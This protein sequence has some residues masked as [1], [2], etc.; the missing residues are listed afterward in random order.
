MEICDDGDHI[1]WEITVCD[2]NDGSKIH[3]RYLI[4]EHDCLTISG[5]DK[6]DTDDIRH[7][8]GFLAKA[9]GIPFS[10]PGKPPKLVLLGVVD[11]GLVN[12][13]KR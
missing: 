8:T 6:I 5:I 11:K 3:T 12:I 1:L 4:A 2:T 7:G 10:A 9:L 13:I